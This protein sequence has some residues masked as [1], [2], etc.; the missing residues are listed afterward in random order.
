MKNIAI[1]PKPALILLC[2]ISISLL[3]IGPDLQAAS[4][5]GLINK[6]NLRLKALNS[7]YDAN[8]SEFRIQENKIKSITCFHVH[9]IEPIS[10]L[11]DLTSLNIYGSSGSNKELDLSSISTLE[12][13][14]SIRISSIKNISNLS[15]LVNL[16]KLTSL[17]IN[18]S[19][20]TELCK[21]SS[22]RSLHLYGCSQIR[23]LTAL[24]T[25]DNLYSVYITNCR[26]L[27]SL[28]GLQAKPIVNFTLRDC[29]SLTSIE[30]LVNL[31]KLTRITIPK[32][33]ADPK[34]ISQLTSLTEIS[35]LAGS[36]YKK[37]TPREFLAGSDH[38]QGI[39]TRSES[40]TA[41]EI[42][43]K[44]T[45]TSSDIQHF[46]VKVDCG[47]SVGSG[48]IAEDN[49]KTYVYTNQHV[50]LGA[51]K[52]SLTTMKGEKIKLKSYNFSQNR[53]IIRFRIE[54]RAALQFAG[55]TPKIGDPIAVYGNSD[56]GGVVTQL[57]GKVNGVG[58][59]R[60][61]VSAT[62]TSGISGSPIVNKEMDIIG[63]ATYAT[64]QKLE[65]DW[66]KRGT[67]FAEVRRFGYR[68]NNIEWK[69]YQWSK[70]KD[71]C[72]KIIKI[73]ETAN[74]LFDTAV[75]WSKNPLNEIDASDDLSSELKSWVA[76]NNRISRK[77][78]NYKIKGFRRSYSSSSYTYGNVD[79]KK[80]STANKT[81][82]R[83]VKT[84]Y[85]KLSALCSKT[86][87]RCSSTV[88]LQ[89]KYTSKFQQDELKR[90]SRF[91]D[92]LAKEIDQY[93][94]EFSASGF[95]DANGVSQK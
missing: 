6:V 57:Y 35:I 80:V 55:D 70:F 20:I 4:A 39:A 37:M 72:G 58:P 50:V 62:F 45:F 24:S 86:S 36:D 8:K 33:L 32:E 61:E 77:Y 49:G 56:G 54:D 15:S 59:D 22:L 11:S 14:T 74:K 28:N 23:D 78:Q 51:D 81:L 83:E 3:P 75:L 17:S 30:P 16:S 9:D 84:C 27:S 25:S 34:V 26:S 1:I 2:S 12:N 88:S 40:Q 63:I 79:Y 67:R 46:L 5:S 68:F 47:N 48:F 43:L 73:E 69:S 85:K 29:P 92:F 94:V 66:I 93:G 38:I 87:K 42:S 95:F 71:I 10:A 64:Q 82:A 90:H 13:L 60:I 65:K 89:K 52:I 31:N 91:M 18:R 21:L 76:T 53:D 7:D 44:M 19:E 41:K